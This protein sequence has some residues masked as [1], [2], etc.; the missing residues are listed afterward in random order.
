MINMK[1][2]LLD[3]NENMT[4]AWRTYFGNLNNIE[5]VNDSFLN[6]MIEH[7]DINGIVAPANSFGLM[8][9]GY[10]KAIID[11]LGPGAQINVSTALKKAYNGYQPV[12]TCCAIP[13]SNYFILHTPT[14]R[15]PE[16]IIDYRVI[17]DCMRSCL[18]KAKQLK[19]DAVVVPAFGALTGRIP[20]DLVAKLMYLAYEHL[21]N[22][23]IEIDWGYALAV[24]NEI[25]LNN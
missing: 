8:T 4:Y 19:L 24:A 14:M 20:H 5:I 1:I 12:G 11:Y 13:Y 7:P 16:P 18:L 21:N 3:I 9:G 25:I 17:Y 10:D 15:T 23:P 22:P 2:Y 6:F